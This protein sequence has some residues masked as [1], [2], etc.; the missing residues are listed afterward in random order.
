MSIKASFA[1]SSLWVMAGTGASNLAAFA[2]FVVLARLL[3]PYTLGIV[4]FAAVF[5][6]IGRIVVFG[7]L[8]EAVIQRKDWDHDVSST[9]FTVNLAISLFFLLVTAVVIAPLMS[10]YYAEEFGPILA[11]LAISFVIDAVRVI[12]EAKLR[13]EFQYK[14]LAARGAIATVISGAIGIA[15]AFA[16]YGV[17]ALV[18]QRLVSA[19]VFTL[20]TLRS[21]RW[22]PSIR[23]SLP[24]LR[25]LSGFMV[26]LT[27]AR[28]ISTASVKVP[29][30]VLGI[31][32][33]PAA[34]AFYRVGARGLDALSKLT[35]NP[36][37]TTALSAFSR[38]NGPEAVAAGYHRVTRVTAAVTCPLYFG[39]AATAPDFVRIVFGPQWDDSAL[40]MA[41]LAMA[42]GP[43]TIGYFSQPALTAVGR[44]G[45][46]LW[47]NTAAFVMNVI[48]SL[49]TVAFGPAGVAL[50]SVAR[51][52]LTAPLGFY[53][54]RKG[55]PVRWGTTLA[56]IAP[57]FLAGLAMLAAVTALRLTLLEDAHILVRVA[58]SVALGVVVYAGLLL[59]FARGYLATVLAELASLAPRRLRGVVR[60]LQKLLPEKPGAAG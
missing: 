55:V 25:S 39:M 1:S 45:R 6:D 22:T 21:A 23:F 43:I 28:L 15:M 33:G 57:P 19:A 3:D 52:Y 54:L 7:G 56:G 30:F 4:A 38:L 18:A 41:A 16:G 42:V 49:A 46:V 10:A 14:L 17:W 40:V 37:Q 20:M 44:T 34:V 12:H 24:I 5:I 59:I 2:V 9:C 51:A 53:N 60:R 35:I 29:E 27:P 11:V 13:R 47:I 32:V 36:V 48:V 50:G 58:A 31:F 8:P 26:H